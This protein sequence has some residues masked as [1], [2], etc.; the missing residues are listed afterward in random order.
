MNVPGKD[1]QPLLRLA[2]VRHD[3]LDSVDLELKSGELVFITGPSGSGKTRLLRAVADLDPHQGDIWLEGN[4][5]DTFAPCDW[6]RRVGWLPTES[7]WWA[8]HAADH[9]A[10]PPDNAAL[11]DLN[12]EPAVLKRPVDQLSTGERQRFALLRLLANT[13]RIML[14]DEPTAS[15][16]DD[17]AGRVESRIRAYLADSKGAALWVSHDVEQTKRLASRRFRMR[18]G[19]LQ[20]EDEGK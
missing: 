6:R 10:I 4:H 13:P 12:L 2:G 9:F 14:L 16:D 11:Q 17:S 19:R 20:A 5:C 18:N 8:R 3:G 15:L 1:T 7:H